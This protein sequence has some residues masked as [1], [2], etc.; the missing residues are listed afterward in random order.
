MSEIAF[1]EPGPE[2]EPERVY[3]RTDD[4]YHELSRLAPGDVL[5]I[6]GTEYVVGDVQPVA[7]DRTMPRFTVDV[8]HQHRWVI[9]QDL[10]STTVTRTCACGAV[11]VD[12][13]DVEGPEA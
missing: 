5:V 2:R 8:R 6:N 9:D 1:Y 13:I 10:A 12:E 7:A 4:G 11:E 3:L